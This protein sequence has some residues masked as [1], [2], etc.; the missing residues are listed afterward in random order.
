MPTNIVAKLNCSSCKIQTSEIIKEYVNEDGVEAIYM[1]DDEIILKD[2]Y[3]VF[4]SEL[5]ESLVTIRSDGT[6]NLNGIAI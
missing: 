3:N 1:T 4:E 6:W 2:Y 5:S